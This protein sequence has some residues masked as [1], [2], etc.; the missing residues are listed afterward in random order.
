MCMSG[1]NKTWA[2]AWRA[3]LRML[4]LWAVCISCAVLMSMCRQEPSPA[5]VAGESLLKAL[6][7]LDN[8]DVDAYLSHVDIG[9]GTC[10]LDSGQTAYMK[11]ALNQHL[12]WR[13]ANRRKIVSIDVVN[14]TMLCDS[15]CTI[16]Y[17]YTYADSTGEVAS[18]K[19]VRYGD[20][21]KLRL[22]N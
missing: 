21:W 8:D 10:A 9:N 5:T 2:H 13:R 3:L 11:D 15:V 7:A 20:E 16:Y 17:Q 18:Q 12:G 4:P 19:M 1:K 14:A 22:R 6:R